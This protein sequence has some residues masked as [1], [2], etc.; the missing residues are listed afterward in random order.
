MIF[1]PTVITP[2]P[3]PDLTHF[4]IQGF[5]EHSSKHYFFRSGFTDVNEYWSFQLP[6]DQAG[7][8]IKTY[9][10]ANQIPA[11]SD[12]SAIPE[13]V[14][15]NIRHERW[16]HRYWFTSFEQLDEIYYQKYLFCGYS[17]KAKRIYLMNW[18]D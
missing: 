4:R 9:V 16:D 10:S 5:P 6:P 13:W 11:L 3:L 15:G 12:T 7:S 8:F 17:R 14:L 1:E 18:N 2:P